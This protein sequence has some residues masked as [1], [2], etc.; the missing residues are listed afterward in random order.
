MWKTHK[1]F[2]WKKCDHFIIRGNFRWVEMAIN[3]K[4]CSQK[5]QSNLLDI[6]LFQFRWNSSAISQMYFQNF[7]SNCVILKHSNL[8]FQPGLISF[9]LNF[10]DLMSLQTVY[11]SLLFHKVCGGIHEIHAVYFESL[12]I[13]FF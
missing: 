12:Q 10:V 8:N 6:R 4:N 9:D 5:W 3:L 11:I 13:F 2:I 1:I 7:Q